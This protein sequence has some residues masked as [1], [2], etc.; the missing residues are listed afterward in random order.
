[1][2][3]LITSRLSDSGYDFID[4]AA[5]EE[6]LAGPPADGAEID[7]IIAKSM[8]KQPLSVEE[9]SRLLSNDAPEV[10]E[11]IY[12]AARQLKRDV[13][14]NRIV[15]FAP[16]TSATCAATIA[17]IAPSAARTNRWCAARLKK[18]TSGGRCSR[19]SRW[20]TSG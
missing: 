17:N 1:M 19:W 3:S 18:K 11:R 4:E 9:T 5:L 14:G 7:D 2:T 13:Y 8:A 16:C 12:A 20:A 10:V 6:L 15:L